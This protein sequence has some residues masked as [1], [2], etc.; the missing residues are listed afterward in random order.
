MLRHTWLQECLYISQPPHFRYELL[1]L[2]RGYRFDFGVKLGDVDLE[3]RRVVLPTELTYPMIQM[4]FAHSRS[5]FLQ[6]FERGAARGFSSARLLPFN[7][8]L[9]NVCSILI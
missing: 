7:R 5:P 8:S 2:W 6:S 9:R 3:A 4:F 1:F